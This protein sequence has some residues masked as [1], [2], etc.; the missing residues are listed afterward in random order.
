MSLPD[1]RSHYYRKARIETAS[2]R[3]LILMA[4]DRILTDIEAAMKSIEIEEVE[5]ANNKLI[6]AQRIVNVL[7]EAVDQKHPQVDLL[8]NF[9]IFLKRK[10]L[11]ANMEKDP[12]ILQGLLPAIA[13]IR[14]AWEM[15]FKNQS[16]HTPRSTTDTKQ[17]TLS[18][19]L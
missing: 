19:E 13:E 9:Y 18:V 8:V 1:S 14:N 7:L 12:A 5:A 4:Y 16:S 3:Q 11:Q 15:G 2:Q 10:L 6:H 17:Q